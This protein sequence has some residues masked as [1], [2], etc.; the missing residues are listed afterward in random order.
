M[1]KPLTKKQAAKVFKDHDVNDEGKLSGNYLVKALCFLGLPV[2]ET[3][4]P[5]LFECVG[6][7]KDKF[8][9][10]DEFLEIMT[11]LKS[12]ED[13]I[14]EE[15]FEEEESIADKAF[16]ML[17]DPSTNGIT[18]ESLLK[19]CKEQDETW[20][21]QQVIEMMHEADLNHD[22]MIDSKEFN[23]ICKKAGL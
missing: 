12:N 13:D 1:K 3:D 17:V 23:M 7:E 14:E 8:V 5:D 6:R 10:L 22:G 21:R 16:E 15:D 18:L 20:T 4:I 19:A 11:E 9:N 2:T